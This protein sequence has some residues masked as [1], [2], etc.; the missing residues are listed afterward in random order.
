MLRKYAGQEPAHER[1]QVSALYLLH[2]FI[3]FSLSEPNCV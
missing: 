2:N 3:K 1:M